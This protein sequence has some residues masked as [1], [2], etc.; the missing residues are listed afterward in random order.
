MMTGMVAHAYMLD[1]CLPGRDLETWRTS[2]ADMG[3]YVMWIWSVT[4][5][6]WSLV[7]LEM[8]MMQDT[9]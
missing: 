2:L 1:I 6:L 4:M 5:L 9:A 3:E 7:I 8:P